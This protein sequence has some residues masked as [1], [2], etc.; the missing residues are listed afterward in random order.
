MPLVAGCARAGIGGVSEPRAAVAGACRRDIFAAIG[1]RVLHR[2]LRPPGEGCHLTVVS[3][4]QR[5]GS[6][7]IACAVGLVAV[8]VGCDGGSVD[9]VDTDVAWSGTA[10][11]ATPDD[12]VAVTADD[13]PFD[14]RPADV[15]CPP[16]GSSAEDGRFEVETDVCRYGTFAHPLPVALRPGDTVEATVWHLELWAPERSEGHAALRLGDHLLWERRVPI[17]GQEAIYPIAVTV[18]FSVAAG[19]PLYFHVHNHGANSWRLL[20][21]QAHRE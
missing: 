5:I 12:W 4:T 1:R 21:V 7:H 11:L 10:V 18:D 17:P 13:D 20:D 9:A 3:N 8:A 2:R 6:R 19:T 15:Q 14:D 16:H